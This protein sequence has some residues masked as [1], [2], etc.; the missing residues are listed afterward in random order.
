M[1]DKKVKTKWIMWGSIAASIILIACAGSFFVIQNMNKA[2]NASGP[3]NITV[4]DVAYFNS[5]STEK[6]CPAGFEYGGIVDVANGDGANSVLNCNYYTNAEIPEWIYVYSTI[7]NGYPSSNIASTNGTEITYV[8]FATREVLYKRCIMFNGQLY[9]SMS[10]YAAAE[11]NTDS[12]WSAFHDLESRYGTRVET[13]PQDCALAGSA[14]LEEPARIPKTE[15][16]INVAE[17]DK[18]D[19]YADPD[20]SQVLYVSTS[21]HTAT[22]EEKVDTLHNGY[23]VFVQ[24][25]PDAAK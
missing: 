24:Y 1:D 14:H 9:Q 15:L 22:D 5:W 11:E 23:D 12:L 21:W 2:S 16:G 7:M 13:I 20:D 3:T 19:V 25:N 18:S 10:S 8:L 17:Y 6:E 4:N